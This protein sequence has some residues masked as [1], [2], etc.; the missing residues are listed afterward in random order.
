MVNIVLLH[1]F[2]ITLDQYGNGYVI[3]DVLQ[4]FVHVMSCP[5]KASRETDPLWK[6]FGELLVQGQLHMLNFGFTQGSTPVT[7]PY[8]LTLSLI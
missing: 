1:C 4:S 6:M 3:T 8:H 5:K 2:I 7:L